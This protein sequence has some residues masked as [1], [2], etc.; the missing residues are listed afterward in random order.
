[1]P[2]IFLS[3]FD[4]GFWKM[5]S[6]IVAACLIS[7]LLTLALTETVLK[8]PYKSAKVFVR[9]TIYIPIKSA[10]G[11][12]NSTSN[13]QIPIVTDIAPGSSL[14]IGHAYGAPGTPIDKS[15]F[16]SESAELFIRKHAASLDGVI[17]TGDVFKIPSAAKWKRL[18]D[19]SGELGV[20]FYI[21]PG[22]HDV[23]LGDNP[24]RDVWKLSE[25]S[26]PATEMKAI[27]LSGFNVFL[28]DSVISGWQ[29]SP[30]VLDA[31]HGSGSDGPILLARH[32]IAIREMTAVANSRA[33]LQGGLPGLKEISAK[34]PEDT[35][36]I[37][38]DS[39]AVS[40][41]PRLTCLKDSRATLVANGI[42]DVRGDAVL[43]MH[44]GML[45][46]ALL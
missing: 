11:R 14:I 38:G 33:G 22:N 20:R 36:I 7:A 28:E 29:I 25:Y 18:S 3:M 8:G 40:R 4:L 42:G 41:L 24:S 27:R 31:L 1:M 5:N 10:T 37:S 35:T 30:E 2:G 43:I 23:G 44:D 39:G 45:Y 17:F 9:D 6:R 19:F 46:Q 12:G 13:C 15:F 32:N 26:L 16:I 21:A 34:V